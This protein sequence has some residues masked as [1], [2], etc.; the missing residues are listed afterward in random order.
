[1]SDSQNPMD[2]VLYEMGQICDSAGVGWLLGIVCYKCTIPLGL[3][4]FGGSMLCIAKN[5]V[6]R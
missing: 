4:G 5:V 6:K 1:M 2:F 3:V